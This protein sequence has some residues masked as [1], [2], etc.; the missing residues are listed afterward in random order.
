MPSIVQ[1]ITYLITILKLVMPYVDL[2]F[3][4]N[5][6]PSTIVCGQVQKDGFL[7]I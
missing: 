3:D 7:Y 4:F 6:T 5:K 2:S 1:S